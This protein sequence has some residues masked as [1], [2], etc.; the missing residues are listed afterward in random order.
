MRLSPI[1]LIASSFLTA[2]ATPVVDHQPVPHDVTVSIPHLKRGWFHNFAVKAGLESDGVP[3]KERRS[4]N[5]IPGTGLLDDGVKARQATDGAT[6]P[7]LPVILPPH[8]SAWTRFKC[9]KENSNMDDSGLCTVFQV[10]ECGCVP[11]E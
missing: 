1:I 2:L 9:W 11:E 10:S 7:H 5:G 4:D 8:R 6:G 3:V